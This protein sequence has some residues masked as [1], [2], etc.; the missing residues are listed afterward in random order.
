M[1][2]YD[3]LC[4]ILTY[5]NSLG[6]DSTGSMVSWRKSPWQDQTGTSHSNKAATPE[7]VA[8]EG[9]PS[10]SAGTQLCRIESRLWLQEHAN[11][12]GTR[13][14]H[15]AS[16]NVWN[17]QTMR[18]WNKLN[19]TEYWIKWF[20]MNQTASTQGN[21]T[22]PDFFLYFF[23]Y[24]SLLDLGSNHP[25]QRTAEVQST[26]CFFVGSLE[27]GRFR[28][29]NRQ[30]PGKVMISIQCKE[31][32]KERGQDRNVP[33]MEEVEKWNNDYRWLM[34]IIVYIFLLLHFIE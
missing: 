21:L 9:R 17:R 15:C 8:K 22:I 18:N 19:I 32:C 12:L 7:L 11:T 24:F 1:I 28:N 10:L 27:H 6:R 5:L 25:F 29:S 3:I 26:V 31:R 16:A 20:K 34:M 14:H 2:Y 23:K 33:G 13:G 4:N 30:P